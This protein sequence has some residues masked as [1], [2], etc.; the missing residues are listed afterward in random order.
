MT[1]LRALL[2]ALLR[3]GLLSVTLG[4]CGEESP[5]D[6]GAGLL[7]AGLLRTVEVTIDPSRYLV[8]DTSFSGYGSPGGTNLLIVAD[9]RDGL[10]RSHGLL[11]FGPPQRV[12]SGPD[13]V[14]TTQ[15]DSVPEILSSRIVIFVDTVA[16]HA[17]SPVTVRIYESQEAWDRL[18][19][20]WTMRVDSPTSQI[21]WEQ[22]GGTIG[23]LIGVGQWNPAV[24]S[25]LV[26][27]DTM[28]VRTWEDTAVVRRGAIVVAD[29]ENS[30]FRSNAVSWRIDYR[31]AFNPDSVIVV[32]QESQARSFIFD[33]PAPTSTD[34]LRIAGVPGW[35]TVLQLRERL[36]TLQV[37]C[38]DQPGC[39]MPLSRVRITRASVQLQG[40]ASPPG[41]APNDSIRIAAWALIPSQGVP[42]ARS[43]LGELMGLQS[44]PIPPGPALAQYAAPVTELLRLLT[45]PPDTAAD[46]IPPYIALTPFT[47]GRS[48][49][50]ATFE[51]LPP[52]RIVYTVGT[53][54]PL[55]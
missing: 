16:S 43:P 11:R 18:T 55:R 40:V 8:R 7:P 25:V 28:Y 10:L 13:T 36:D 48:F 19:A 20:S 22:P 49:G 26:A 5:T 17:A 15:T 39:T 51:P 44:T 41:F 23:P 47:E 37:P 27:I 54:V 42:L 50:F 35:R 34:M 4:A 12:V 1:R 29:G 46:P 45:E 53:E 6:V 31:P 30:L 2:A 3:V 21:P 9:Q 24:D 32:T 14:G 38:P 52:L 33:P